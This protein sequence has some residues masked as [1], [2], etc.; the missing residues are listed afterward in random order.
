MEKLNHPPLFCNTL[1]CSGD[2]K[3]TGWKMRQ[4]NGKKH[5]V[6][7]FKNCNIEVFAAGDSFNDLAMIQI[8]DRGALFCAPP[9]IK[10]AH[11]NIPST[12]TY[13][14]LMS[15]IDSFLKI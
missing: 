5:A 10:E 8:S 12:E 3:I 11:K 9:A 14:E 4:Q 13:T 2:G 1:V 15:Q 7:A 6:E